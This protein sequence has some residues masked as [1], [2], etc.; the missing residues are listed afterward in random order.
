ME[1]GIHFISGLP[2]SG[3][4]LLAAILRQNP[5]FHA[6]MSSPVAQMFTSVQSAMSGRN[7]FSLFIEEK[8]RERVL[9]GIVE[10]YYSDLAPTK[11]IFDTNRMW[12][13]RI[14]ALERLFPQAKLICCVRPLPKIFDSIERIV[15]ANPLAPSKMFKF[16]A[17]GN[18]YSRVGA[19][20]SQQGMVG[21]AYHGLKDAFFGSGSP[22]LVLLPYDVLSQRPA[23]AISQLYAFLGLP[24][25]AHDFD[26]VKYEADEFDSLLGAPG[27]HRVAGKVEPRNYPS[28]LPPDLLARFGDSAFWADPRRNPKGVRVIGVNDAPGA[29][30][31]RPLNGIRRP[32]SLTP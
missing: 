22:K 11:T 8:Q 32:T 29:A 17:R 31:P 7:E 19:L 1:N 30:A 24:E 23:Y 3:S 28:T 4:T 18:V 25:F 12:A 10:N 5:L 15:R 2:R 27:L 26:N 16:E 14:Y 20:A 6:A 21:S 13:G 9:R